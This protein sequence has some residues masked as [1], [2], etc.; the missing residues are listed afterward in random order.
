M[1]AG[2]R[3]RMASDVIE[4]TAQ[5]FFSLDCHTGHNYRGAKADGLSRKRREETRDRSIRQ[6]VSLALVHQPIMQVPP[7]QTVWR[8]VSPCD[9][10]RPQGP[11]PQSFLSCPSLF[12]S[13]QREL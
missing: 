5:G 7:G 4:K 13:G 1:A 10:H 8:I 2:Q 11:Q 3:Q 12:R 9:D 6:I